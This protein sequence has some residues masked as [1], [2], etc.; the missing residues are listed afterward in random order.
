M[1]LIPPQMMM[2]IMISNQWAVLEQNLVFK[3]LKLR[4]KILINHWFLINTIQT[5]ARKDVRTNLIPLRHQVT[6]RIHTI[7]FSNMNPFHLLE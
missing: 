4:Q 3:V 5:P 7:V 1:I 2:P 6:Q